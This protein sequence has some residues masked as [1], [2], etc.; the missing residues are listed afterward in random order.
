MSLRLVLLA[1]C[2]AEIH[3]ISPQRAIGFVSSLA[4]D[5]TPTGQKRC[6]RTRAALARAL[7]GDG[8][9]ISD[10]AILRATVDGVTVIF[11]RAPATSR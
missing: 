8:A 10:S 4:T 3:E 6:G 7:S 2:Q 9:A 5:Q 11:H 1:F